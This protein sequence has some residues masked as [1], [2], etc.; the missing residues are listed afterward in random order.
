MNYTR[1]TEVILNALSWW[2]ALF[3]TPLSCML[4]MW[5]ATGLIDKLTCSWWRSSTSSHCEHTGKISSYFSF[6][7]KKLFLSWHMEVHLRVRDSEYI[8]TTVTYSSYSSTSLLHNTW[9]VKTPKEPMSSVLSS[10]LIQLIPK[11][12]WLVYFLNMEKKE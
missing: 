11:S 9:D 6:S 5:I 2:R 1:C 10:L 12:P 4:C 8:F 3:A 7:I